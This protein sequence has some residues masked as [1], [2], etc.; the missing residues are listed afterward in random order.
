M[1]VAY[2]EAMFEIRIIQLLNN[3]YFDLSF[4]ISDRNTE[5]L[6]NTVW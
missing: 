2:F 1:L 4:V 5:L 3:D 6:T